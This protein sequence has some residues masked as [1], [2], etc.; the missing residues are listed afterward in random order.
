[1]T[2]E[3]I[4][5]ALAGD[6]KTDGA[7]LTAQLLAESDRE[8]KRYIL[9]LLDKINEYEELIEA[10]VFPNGVT[11]LSFITGKCPYD[12]P[13]GQTLAEMKEILAGARAGDAEAQ[14]KAA[15]L[16]LDGMLGLPDT[17]HAVEYL[18]A[19]AQSGYAEAYYELGV[20]AI[21]GEGLPRDVHAAKAYYEEAARLGSVDAMLALASLYR[22]GKGLAEDGEKMYYWYD[23]AAKAGSPNG[24]LHLAI[25]T[26][27]GSGTEAS[28]EK[29]IA[30]AQTAE[31]MGSNDAKLLL[32]RLQRYY[33]EGDIDAN[34]L[35]ARNRKKISD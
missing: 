7:F 9:A 31:E 30:L 34:E 18:R 26:F 2:K 14:Y 13:T 25:C 28:I 12:I 23:K 32:R 3:E 27:N 5:A 22:G 20:C 1:M 24:Y 16:M 17:A 21:N 33:E 19:A 6:P 8:N 11:Y 15:L 10:G 29:A 35:A 4:T